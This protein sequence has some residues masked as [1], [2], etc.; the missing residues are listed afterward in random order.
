MSFA[1]RD[2]V[3]PPP[4]PPINILLDDRQLSRQ[5]RLREVQSMAEELGMGATDSGV[6]RLVRLHVADIKVVY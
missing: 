1:I 3:L 5:H 2:A 6:A 4:L